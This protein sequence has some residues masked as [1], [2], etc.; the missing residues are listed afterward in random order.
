MAKDPIVQTSPSP[1]APAPAQKPSWFHPIQRLKYS[2]N[3]RKARKAPD[4]NPSPVTSTKSTFL[5]NVK[6][7][8]DEYNSE[9]VQKYLN[10]QY[11]ETLHNAARQKDTD[12]NLR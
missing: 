2:I 10:E 3:E 9:I 5:D 8:K 12:P 7:S 1:L 6:L 11:K 4:K